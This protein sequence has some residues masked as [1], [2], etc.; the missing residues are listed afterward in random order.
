[1]YGPSEYARSG[2]LLAF[3]P[4]RLDMS[5]HAAYQVDKILKGAKP[6]D[7]PVE[8]AN[9]FELIVNQR[10][11]RALALTIPSLLLLRADQVIA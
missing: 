8:Q 4:N 3:G 2:G 7:L 9:K 5:R 1:M 11:A 6:G 10:A